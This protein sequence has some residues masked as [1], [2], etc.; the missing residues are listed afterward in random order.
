MLWTPAASS[1]TGTLMINVYCLSG[2]R[3]T[4]TPLEGD[5]PLPRNALWIDLVHPN[6]EEDKR[7]ERLTG[8]AIPTREDMGEIEESSRFYTEN[9]ALYLIAPLIHAADTDK[10]GV[11][12]V[13]F[14]L[15]GKLLISVRYAEP[16]SFSNY[17]ARAGKAGS[18]LVNA[19]CDGLFIL[20]GI[21]ESATDRIADILETVAKELDESSSGMFG[22]TTRRN[23][24]TNA[25]FK[26]LLTRIGGQGEF[27]SKVRESLA[28][29]DRMCAYLAANNKVATANKDV[30]AW[31]KSIDRDV[32]SLEHHVDF[33]SNRITFLMDTMV[34]LISV[35]Q[36]AIIKIFSV[37]A[38]AFMP[39]TLVAS[40]Y[41]M[42]FHHMPEIPQPWGYPVALGA[43]VLSAVLPLVYFRWRGWL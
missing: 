2:D 3:L 41:G 43:M 7:V 5:D 42:N 36:N 24:M 15:H 30:R 1:A 26:A 22:R 4:A 38:V 31:I 6:S 20:L 13:S 19:R 9:G 33:L 12:P 32:L 21:I 28:G 16:R 27:L 37:A 25:R 11:S 18:G 8:V 17:A 40:I 14:I 35:E 29:L 39:P 23:A 10:P 34:G